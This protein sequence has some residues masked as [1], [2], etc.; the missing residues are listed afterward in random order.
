MTYNRTDR[1]TNKTLFLILSI[2]GLLIIYLGITQLFWAWNILTLPIGLMLCISGYKNFKRTN[3]IIHQIEFQEDQ[4]RIQYINGTE[5]IVSNDKFNYSLLVKKFHKP[6]RSIEFI[7]KRKIA[8]RRG[9]SL[10]KI[11]IKKWE[12][13]MLPIAKYLIQ[14]GYDRKKWKF[15]WGAG[16]FMMIFALVMGF[17]DSIA[18]NFILDISG[19]IGEISQSIGDLGSE[20]SDAKDRG[21]HESNIAEKKFLDKNKK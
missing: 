18:D 1:N 21:I 5:K 19:G 7:E 16:E 11:E 3:F 20:I 14:K 17:A 12:D 4:V 6:V 15:S 10:G 9:K 8:L 13:D 2:L